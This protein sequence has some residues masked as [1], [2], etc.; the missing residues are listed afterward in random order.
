MELALY[1][2]VAL[3]LL[4]DMDMGC[5]VHVE[6]TWLGHGELHMGS[7]LEHMEMVQLAIGL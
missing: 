2:S 3:A 5:L 4:G 1:L 6:W 7:G